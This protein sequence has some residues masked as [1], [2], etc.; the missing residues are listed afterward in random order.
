MKGKRTKLIFVSLRARWRELVGKPDELPRESRGFNVVSLYMI[1]L[2]AILIPLDFYLGLWQI[3]VVLMVT[4]VMLVTMFCLSRYRG[5]Y[6]TGLN[7][8]AIY[9]Y[10]LVI[11]TYLYN[12]GSTGPALYFF[13]L[14][15]QLLIVFTSQRF[16]WGWTVLHLLLPAGLLLMEYSYPSA[17]I[18]GYSFRSSRFIDL[19]T[20]F[21][22]IVICIFATTSYLRKAYER[23]RTAAQIRAK[24]IEDQNERIRSQNKLLQKANREKIELI[25]ILGHDLRNPM[26]AITGA[27]EI[28][29]KEELPADEQKKLKE[30]LLIAAHN[31]S[32]L[33]NNMLS[34]VSGQ[35]KGISPLLTWVEPHLVIERALAVQ[36]FIAEKKGIII[37]L[38]MNKDI[39]IRSDADMLELIIRNLVNNALKFTPQNGRIA[40]T[41]AADPVSKRCTI[42]VRDDG[43][44]MTDEEVKGIFN[45]SIQSAY[46]TGSEK[47]IG[48]D[49]FLCRELMFRL[50]G[51]IQLESEL[52]KGS[53]FSLILP[54]H[55][56]ASY[57]DPTDPILPEK[58]TV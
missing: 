28:L 51:E 25:S 38:H 48:L 39:K 3:A 17:L 24:Q 33:L 22:I 57:N 21:P 44:G 46:G 5:L 37:Q 1:V 53:I 27:L 9:S 13:L 58:T 42:S 7:V 56:T 54:F 29:A 2:L 31:T 55:D 18:A 4:E 8:Y 36:G 10:V 19:M 43:V 30:D 32:D 26:N 11:F 14:T 41:L 47:G 34:W 35:I 15:Y 40:V 6:R 50:N 52:G 45:G 49:L 16:Q 23:E 12:G 20:S